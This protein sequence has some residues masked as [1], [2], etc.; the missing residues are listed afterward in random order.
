MRWIQTQLQNAGTAL[1][2]GDETG[3]EN[4]CAFLVA[5]SSW[6]WLSFWI[7]LGEGVLYCMSKS[8]QEQ[9]RMKTYYKG[10][11]PLQQLMCWLTCINTFALSIKHQQ[12]QQQLLSFCNHSNSPPYRFPKVHAVDELRQDHSIHVEPMLE[13]HTQ[14]TNKYSESCLVMLVV[15]WFRKLLQK[16]LQYQLG[17]QHNGLNTNIQMIWWYIY[18]YILHMIYSEMERDTP[19]IR[20]KLRY[21]KL[22]LLKA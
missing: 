1:A 22:H 7:K 21:V 11:Y 5:F 4:S 9:W 16:G 13:F 2:V 17:G 15:Y 14:P 19:Q 18:I 3:G 6:V 10:T 12:Q 8:L 20:V